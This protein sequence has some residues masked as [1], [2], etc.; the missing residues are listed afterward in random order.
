MGAQ[1]AAQ[2]AAARAL[3][4]EVD[5]NVGYNL[6]RG[7]TDKDLQDEIDNATAAVSDYATDLD[8]NAIDEQE[9]TETAPA[10]PAAPSQ[11][12]RP[13]G[14][15]PSEAPSGDDTETGL[16]TSESFTARGGLIQRPKRKAK[17]T[18]KKRRGLASR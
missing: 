18:K 17:N 14:S 8:P 4:I 5:P 11:P 16:G 10:A 9:T 1:A 2:A 3:G 7:V 12:D 6:A 13:G 15:G